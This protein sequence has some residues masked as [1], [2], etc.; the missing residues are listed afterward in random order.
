METQGKTIEMLDMVALDLRAQ[1]CTGAGDGAPTRV[2]FIFGLGTMGTTPFENLLFGKAPGDVLSLRIDA[3]HAPHLFGHL[4]CTVLQA[5]PQVP[6]FDLQ[7]TVRSV[8]K[9]DNREVVKAMARMGGCGGDCGC[10]CGG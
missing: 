4:Q 1:P 5:L 6:P 7:V 10:G 2:A 3:A 9:A 8:E